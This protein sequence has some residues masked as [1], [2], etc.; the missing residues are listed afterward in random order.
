MFQTLFGLTTV[1]SP[2]CVSFWALCVF[3]V[4]FG[5]LSGSYS[6]MMVIPARLLGEEKFSLSY[7]FMLAGEGIGVYLGPPLVGKFSSL[8]FLC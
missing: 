2:L 7:G 1:L 8:V 5:F 3:S 4:T 6:L